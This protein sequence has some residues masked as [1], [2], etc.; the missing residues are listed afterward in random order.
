MGRISWIVAANAH[1][2]PVGPTL[3]RCATPGS[4]KTRVCATTRSRAKVAPLMPP[5]PGSQPS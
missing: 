1:R 4:F 5:R 3:Q 2:A